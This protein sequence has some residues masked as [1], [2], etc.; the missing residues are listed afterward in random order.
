MGTPY[1]ITNYG[2]GAVATTGRSI[3]IVTNQLTL[4]LLSSGN[5][6]ISVY[7]HGSGTLLWGSSS[8]AVNSGN[9]IFVNMRTEWMNVQD[10]WST[11]LAADQTNA[12]I[13]VTEYSNG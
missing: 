13:T 1:R 5:R 8:I 6:G 11:Y 3:L 2:I 12:L 4:L 9:N 7:N 10:G